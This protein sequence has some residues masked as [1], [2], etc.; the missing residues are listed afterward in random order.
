VNQDIMP[1]QMKSSLSPVSFRD[2]IPLIRDGL[3]A[4]IDRQWFYAKELVCI[5]PE[6]L[7]TVSVADQLCGNLGPHTRITLEARTRTIVFNIRMRALGWQDFFKH[8]SLWNGR[9]GKVDILLTRDHTGNRMA[10]SEVCVVELKNLDPP[11]V[12]VLK[13]IARL[14]AFLE[15]T[16]NGSPLQVCYLAYPSST[17]AKLM[18][19]ESVQG[20]LTDAVDVTLDEEFELT[21]EDPEDGIPAFYTNVL[22]LARS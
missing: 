21:D 5:K 8:K 16:P 1:I 6:Y 14:L 13:D 17:S 10:P 3:K 20:L 4:G 11:K 2:L 22:R 9:K 18:L 7:L 12:E 15:I 19:A